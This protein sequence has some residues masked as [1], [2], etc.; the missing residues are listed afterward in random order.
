MTQTK[1]P[2]EFPGRF[3][4]LIKKL[5]DLCQLK[6]NVLLRRIKPEQANDQLPIFAGL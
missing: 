1:D 3:S 5:P 4:S 6:S 2:S